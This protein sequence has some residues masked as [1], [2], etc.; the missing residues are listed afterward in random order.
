MLESKGSC[1]ALPASAR[2]LQSGP[3]QKACLSQTRAD[4]TGAWRRQKESTW[5]HL[6]QERVQRKSLKLEKTAREG[7]SQ[8]G[9]KGL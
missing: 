9:E 1:S 7:K 5:V 8:D 3:T 2:I 6:P 4:Y